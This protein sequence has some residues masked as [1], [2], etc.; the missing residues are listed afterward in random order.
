MNLTPCQREFL[1]T[2]DTLTQKGV[3]P[4]FEELAAAR[5][6][7]SLATV[8][9]YVSRLKRHGLLES[10]MYE[11]RSIRITPKGKK[12]LDPK[13]CPHCGGEI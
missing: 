7:S 3:S 12:L 10:E 4:S 6:F 9:M 2:V 11:G 13:K 8:H 1:Q 5:G